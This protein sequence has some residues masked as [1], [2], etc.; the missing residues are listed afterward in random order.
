MIFN[1]FKVCKSILF[2]IIFSLCSCN[3]DN[4]KVPGDAIVRIGDSYLTH[5]MVEQAMEQGISYGSDSSKIASSIVSSWIY[6]QL[7]NDVASKNITDMESIERKVQ[8]YRNSLIAYEYVKLMV[9]TNESTINQITNDTIESFYQSN[10]NQF[11]LSVPI[12][13][14]MVIRVENSCPE[15]NSIK[16]WMKRASKNDVEHLEKLA[17]NDDVSFQ[18]FMDRWIDFNSL[19]ANIPIVA[20]GYDFNDIKNKK[21]LE[22][23]DNDFTYILNISDYRDNGDIMPFD[24]AKSR[25]R[26]IFVTA[27]QQEYEKQL[28]DELYDKAV[29]NG[30]LEI[31]DLSMIKTNSK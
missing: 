21:Y 2:F 14:G 28:K 26:E 3:S 29:A 24:F 6:R 30:D 17:L 25:I 22:H 23:S 18:Y 20:D 5:T 15:I 9:A 1:C 8:D 31:Y 12:I 4:G 16:K 19:N 10:K 7:I 27:K 11:L 13:K